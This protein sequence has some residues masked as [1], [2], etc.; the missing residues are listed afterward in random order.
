MKNREPN[1]LIPIV[2]IQCESG[3]VDFKKKFLKHEDHI[4]Y[5]HIAYNSQQSIGSKI[6]IYM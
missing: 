4:T 3:S 1:A 5:E 6:H 2:G